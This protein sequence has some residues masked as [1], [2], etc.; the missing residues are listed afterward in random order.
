MRLTKPMGRVTVGA[1]GVAMAVLLLPSVGPAGPALLLS[2]AG[3]A[4]PPASAIGSVETASSAVR[5]TAV[6]GGLYHGLALSSTGAV[7]AWGWNIAG[8][9]CNGSTN[10]S[11]VPV[12]VQAARRHEG[13]RDRRRLRP[14]PG[15]DL[16]RRGVRLRQELRR[17]ARQREHDGQRRAG[18]GGPARGH[19]GDRGRR[20]RRAQPGGDLDRRRARLGLRQRRP[21]RQRR[22]GSPAM[23]R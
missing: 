22:H 18:E 23:C 3:A 14:Q 13:D 2:V 20:R 17:R 11:D 6:A 5:V 12:K 16:D 4:T 21:A 10:G 7:F 9:L 15:A 8:Q 1:V 19:E